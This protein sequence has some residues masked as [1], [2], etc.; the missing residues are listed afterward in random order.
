MRSLVY[1]T[2]LLCI[3]PV[4][5]AQDAEVTFYSNG[6]SLNGGLPVVNHA[7]FNG[8]IFDGDQRLAILHHRHFLILHLAVGPHTF[9]A[10]LSSK[11]PAANSQLTVDLQP[12]AQYFIRVDR[13]ARGIMLV[14][15][16]RGHLDL[17]TCVVA[18][19][20]A[21]QTTPEQD[22]RMTIEVR[23]RVVDLLMLPPCS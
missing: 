8:A 3:A 16:E 18:H 5:L 12:N 21:A 20:E 11:H 14:Q 23:A 15:T 7:A 17:V 6:S 22:K 2:L 1:L 9:S 13:A 10:S 19:S 4:T